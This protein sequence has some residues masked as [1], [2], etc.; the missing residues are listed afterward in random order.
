MDQFRLHISLKLQ[1]SHFF[2]EGCITL[3]KKHSRFFYNK[4]IFRGFI[5]IFHENKRISKR[6]TRL[7]Q[8]DT[9]L[10]L[11]ETNRGQFEAKRPSKTNDKKLGG[12]SSKFSNW[13]GDKRVY[14]DTF[15]TLFNYNFCQIFESGGVFNTSYPP[16]LGLAACLAPPQK[17]LQCFV[18]S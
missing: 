9:P 17:H 14:P 10:E 15:I 13:E 5:R 1:K 12:K 6:C 18:M 11:L 16:L 8:S 2:F 3:L 4:W 7:L